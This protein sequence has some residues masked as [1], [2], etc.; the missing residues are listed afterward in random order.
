MAPPRM[1]LYIKRNLQI[2]H[3]FEKYT[4]K[5]DI[6][7]F[8]I[9]ESLLDMTHSWK[10]FGNSPYEVARKIQLDV[11][12]ELGLY[13]T[14]GIG[15]NPL[16]AKYALDIQAK[17]DFSLIGEWHYE[18]VP[19]KLWPITDLTSLCF[20]GKRT[21]KHLNDL[22]IHS[23][24][25]LAHSD[26]Y[27][28]QAKFGVIGAQLFAFSW[29]IDR[30][31]IS[32]KY[33]PK[34]TSYGNSQVLPSDY[35]QDKQIKIVLREISEQVA[36]RLRSHHKLTNCISLGVR[37]AYKERESTRKSGFH[38]S[39]KV[40][41]TNLNEEI[42]QCVLRLFD[43]H[44]QKQPIR[45]LSVYCTQ[46]IDDQGL[47]MN[48]LD[49]D[50]DRTKMQKLDK[51]VDQIRKSFGFKSLVKLSSLEPGATAIKRV[52]LVGGHA[53]GKAYD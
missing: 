32:H 12:K 18:D 39:T 51:T 5:A 24:Y 52:G 20:I 37:F 3:I 8:S 4:T 34:G 23:M 16:L 38:C 47:Q 27:Q 36:A 43:L 31:I 13:V 35:Y 42:T 9:D 25:D 30:A 44:W 1:N 17:H 15:D 7:P 53:G 49:E 29:G 10:L 11:K 46:L 21:A 6:Q 22:G 40:E 14:V 26:P 33:K 2:N 28:I 45:N 50:L 41:P 48:L 19:D